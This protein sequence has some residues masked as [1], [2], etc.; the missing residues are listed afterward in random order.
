[1]NIGVVS[2]TH[3]LVRPETLAFL[4]GSELI[5][6]AGDVG[7]AD[8]LAQ[9]EDVAPVVAIRGNIDKQPG[10]RELPETKLITLANK[11]LYL[12][13]NIHQL[14]LDPV[15][16]ALDVVIYGHSH[17]AEQ[18]ARDGVLYLNP[19]SVGP[20]RFKLPVSAAKLQVTSAGVEAQIHHLVV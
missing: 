19:G 2:D 13:H 9:L 1:M 17:K 10:V 4:Q 7:A 18:F 12:L 16:E 8:V 6:H 14:Q 20:R 5:L 15:A 11:R 3:G